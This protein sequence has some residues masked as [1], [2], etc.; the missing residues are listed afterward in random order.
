[1]PYRILHRRILIHYQI[2]P[3]TTMS[4]R[5]QALQYIL[6]IAWL[7][8]AASSAGATPTNAKPGCNDTCGNIMIPYPFGIGADCANGSWFEI[9][10]NDSTSPP[11]PFMRRLKL[12]VMKV[13]YDYSA[14][15][16]QEVGNKFS[17][18]PRLVLVVATQPLKVCAGGQATGLTRPVSS[19]NLD[20]SP[21][22]FSSPMNGLHAQFVTGCAGSV[23]M[24]NRNNQVLA[25][26]ASVCG[27]SHNSRNCFGVG[28]CQSS[29]ASMFSDS[30]VLNL[31]RIG[32]N[33]EAVG[34]QSTCMDSGLVMLSSYQNLIDPQAFTIT[35]SPD[36]FPTVLEFI[37][38]PSGDTLCPDYYEGNPYLP[39]GCQL[40]PECKKCKG[41]CEPFTQEFGWP[42][43][44]C[45]RNVLESI[46]PILGSM[47]GVVSML[48]ALGCYWF[49]RS[50][51]KRKEIRKRAKYFKRN[52]GFLLQQQI[53]QEGVT[54]KTRVYTTIELEKATD[55]FNQNRILGQGGQGT[56]YK[57]ILLDGGIVAVKKSN[58][59]DSDQ[60]EQF[61]NELVIL[62]QINHRNIVKLL[63]CCL[64]TK[65][66][67]L[68]YEFIPNGTLAQHIQNPV[69]DFQISWK[70]RLQIAIET[71]GA[72]SY[73][74]SSSAAPIYHRD[75][76]SSNILLDSKYR[77]KVSD[78]GTS[79]TITIEQT[80]LTTSVYGTFGY[81][82]PEYFQT[83]QFTEKSDVYS[84][85]VVLVEL[86]TSKKPV[87]ETGPNEWR[88]LAT[89]FLE[90]MG[91]TTFFDFLD[92]R[93]LQEA[94]K[95]EILAIA[96]L[97]ER[98]LNMHGKLRPAMQ[99]VSMTL[100]GVQSG[101]M[102]LSPDQAT[103][104]TQFEDSDIS[105]C[106]SFPGEV[107]LFIDDDHPPY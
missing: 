9:F 44:R 107:S 62:S 96:S 17:Y 84:F 49:Y 12:E 70:M 92:K 59:V 15:L 11:T 41:T 47:I 36:K 77:A 7:Q 33:N 98:C 50:M 73:L 58:Q 2:L 87:F 80:H 95:E 39:D 78:F 104:N 68:V 27:S 4:R 105:S 23:V 88:S 56:V 43:Y 21:Y 69:E 86:L 94:R 29:I 19:V 103:S 51:Q 10:C 22:W 75:I 82:D 66:P 65:V 20:G 55:K 25:G 13:I 81:L 31:Y 8:A 3:K 64:E 48:L 32:F 60:L 102:H 100:Q 52:G 42:S 53:S 14:I 1:M 37:R 74:H 106:F 24:T 16:P 85:G 72:L 18:F 76:K 45:K 99:E 89:E 61:I 67:L 71:A 38:D 40:A 54:A 26:C 6:V 28:C 34:E 57:G 63:G 83:N 93:V 30:D 79:R 5:Q 46:A 97:A 91:S 35:P 90:K 101:G